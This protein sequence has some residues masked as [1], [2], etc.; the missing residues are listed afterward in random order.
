MS[1]TLV[2]ADI[3]GGYKALIQCFQESCFDYEKDKLIFLGDVA[4]GWPETP[5]CIEE[6]MKIKNLIMI[7]GNHDQWCIEWLEKGLTS[8][9]WIEQGG[10]ATVQAYRKEMVNKNSVISLQKHL[11]FLKK[12]HYY[13]LDDQ[14]RLF[15]HGGIKRGV[16]L[17]E[18]YKD[19]FLWDRVI[20]EEVIDK[21][22]DLPEF[23]EV[24]LGHTSI[25]QFS[26][27]PLSYGNVI[28]M[29]TGGGFEGRLTIM[30]IDTKEV[31]QSDIVSQLYPKHTGRM[32]RKDI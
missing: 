2:C 31:W 22:N 14:N 25:W 17:K 24:Y 7:L 3:H 15:V 27:G 10:R 13:Y 26:Q 29:D 16:P 12:A 23:K 4:D 11:N 6:L 32:G 28:C 21:V 18:Q 5:Q 20:A 19:D 1:R 8:M 30:D 9:M